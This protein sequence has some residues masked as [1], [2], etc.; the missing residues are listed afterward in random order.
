[1]KYGE[2]EIQR[3]RFILS[4]GQLGFSVND[5]GEILAVADKGKTPCL[6]VRRLI[7]Q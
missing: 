5:I 3:L 6:L 7:Q 1:M 4:A 2:R